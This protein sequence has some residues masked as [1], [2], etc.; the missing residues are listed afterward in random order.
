MLVGFDVRR[1]NK[2]RQEWALETEE[3]ISGRNIP[4]DKARAASRDKS[5]KANPSGDGYFRDDVRVHRPAYPPLVFVC[6]DTRRVL[7]RHVSVMA[8]HRLVTLQHERYVAGRRSGGFL[9]RLA[10]PPR[11]YP[12]RRVGEDTGGQIRPEE[13]D[14]GGSLALVFLLVHYRTRAK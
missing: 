7:D 10:T 3:G 14:L 12:G 9:D 2:T 11:R 4:E 1:E 13:D 8:V 5:N 6:S